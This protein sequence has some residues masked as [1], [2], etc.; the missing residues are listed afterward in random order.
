VTTILNV[1]KEFLAHFF[2]NIVCWENNVV[3]FQK[4]AW[5][6]LYGILLH[7]WNESFFKLCVLYCGR[8]IHSDSCSVEKERLDYALVFIVTSSFEIINCSEAL[9]I[10]GEMKVNIIEEWGFNIGDDACL[11]DVEDGSNDAQSE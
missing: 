11:Y 7:A 8:F 10:D 9:L 1:A 3:S 4:G 5:L 2:T 6:R